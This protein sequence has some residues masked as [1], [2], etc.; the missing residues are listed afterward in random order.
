MAPRY[1][2]IIFD[3]GD[4]LFD[5]DSSSVTVLPKKLIPQMMGTVTWHN[6]ERNKMQANE[7]FRVRALPAKCVDLVLWP[8]E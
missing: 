7:A 3:L 8:R 1:D 6:L 4:V 5:W 2:A